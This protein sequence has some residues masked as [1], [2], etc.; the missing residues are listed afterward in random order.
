MKP[1]CRAPPPRPSAM[2]RASSGFSAMTMISPLMPSPRHYGFDGGGHL[3]R[4]DRP[5]IAA[6]DRKSTR[7]NPVTNAHLVCRL[8]L[9]KKNK[10]QLIAIYHTH[11]NSHHNFTTNY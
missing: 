11:L 4:A 8:L 2:A 7:L 5:E 6:V 9:E 3:P 1:S 10:R